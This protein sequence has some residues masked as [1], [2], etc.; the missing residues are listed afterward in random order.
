[1]KPHQVNETH[2]TEVV[3]IY[4]KHCGYERDVAK[5][6]YM[7][8]SSIQETL[9]RNGREQYRIGSKWDG[10]SKLE[11]GVNDEGDV[12]V[13]FDPNFDP[14]DRKGKEHDEAVAAGEVFEEEARAYLAAQTTSD[15][16]KSS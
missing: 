11:I 7:I 15:S 12:D 3:S 6:M 5:I 8:G 10:H 4:E 16:S 2:I 13:G 9:K 1:M 14:K